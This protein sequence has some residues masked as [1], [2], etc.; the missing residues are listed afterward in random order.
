MTGS[1]NA[2]N[3]RKKIGSHPEPLGKDDIRRERSRFRRVSTNSAALAVAQRVS[4]RTLRPIVQPNTA[5]PCRN[6]P[7]Q[8]ETP[9]RP[10][11]RAGVGRCG[12]CA[13]LAR[14]DEVIE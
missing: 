1:M 2:K 12:A 14:A 13:Q 5:S 8:P 11:L 3:L 6:A 10:R 7:T 4:I 9:H